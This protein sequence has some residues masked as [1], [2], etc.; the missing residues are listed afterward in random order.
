MQSSNS[1]SFA[2]ISLSDGTDYLFYYDDNK[3]IACLSGKDAS[4]FSITTVQPTP[5]VTIKAGAISPL[6]AAAW[7]SHNGKLEGVSHQLQ[8][9]HTINTDTSL[10]FL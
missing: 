4:V 2:S 9:L 6:A 3:N 5:G 8:S 10:G 7:E 1:I